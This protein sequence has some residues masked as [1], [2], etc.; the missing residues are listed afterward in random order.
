MCSHFCGDDGIDQ[1]SDLLVKRR[2]AQ[3]PAMV[4]DGGAQP[5]EIA[6]DHGRDQRLPVGEIL[7]ETAETPACSATPVV[8]NLRYPTASKT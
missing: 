8:V 4:L 2:A 5:I 6:L 3:L 7:I 1:A